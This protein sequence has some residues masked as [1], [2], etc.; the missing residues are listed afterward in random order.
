MSGMRKTQGGAAEIERRK[1]RV[2]S[3][4]VQGIGGQRDEEMVGMY[5]V[6]VIET[7]GGECLKMKLR[8]YIAQLQDEIST[9]HGAR[10]P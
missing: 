10:L 2:G 4:R 6:R 5:G 7:T 8:I 3:I 9:D 1:S